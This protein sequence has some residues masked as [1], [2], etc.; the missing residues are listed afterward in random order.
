[1]SGI[2]AEP[3]LPR[4]RRLH[5]DA[6]RVPG[7]GAWL[8]AS[9]SFADT[10][11][12]SPSFVLLCSA[13]SACLF[14]IVTLLTPCVV[15]YWT[16]GETMPSPAA[17]AAT[18]FCVTTPFVTWCAPLCLSSLRSL[19]T[20]RSRASFSLRGLLTLV[21]QTRPFLSL[22]VSRLLLLLVVVLPR[23]GSPEVCPVLLR[24]GTSPSLLCSAPPTSLRLL[25]RLL[26]FFTRLKLARVVVAWIASESRTARGLATDLP[27]DKSLR[28]AQRISCT[29]HRENARA[30]LRRSPLSVNGDKVPSTGW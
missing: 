15:R 9:P 8:T 12:P 21:V 27:R 4:H 29:L 2:F 23:S 6:C 10:H 19:L 20:L 30:I 11:V 16:V 1:M 25:R 7:A 26:M 18:R 5:L 3:A 28:I 13:V 14:G 22:L 24:L 17:A